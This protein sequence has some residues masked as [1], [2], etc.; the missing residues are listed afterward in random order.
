MGKTIIFV[1]GRSFKPQKAALQS[2]WFGAVEHGIGRDR[3]GKLA[4]FKKA[5]KELVYYGDLS[6]AFLRSKGSKYNEKKDVESRKQTLAALQGYNARQFTK[7]TYK[8]LPGKASY[9]EFLADV[10][11]MTLGPLRLTEGL[12]SVVAADMRHYWNFDSEF[13][14]NVRA[15]MI[16]P[17]K[18]AMNRGDKI[19]VI[20]HSLGTMVAYDTFWKFS[21]TSEYRP[22]YSNRKIDT[23]ITLGSP[24]GDETVKRNLKGAR[25]SGPRRYPGNIRRWEN[26][27]AEDDFISHD[28]KIANDYK[29]MYK[30]RLIVEINDHKI[31]NLAVRG[32]ASN[33]HHG[34]G[35][36]I[37][38]KVIQLITD[39]L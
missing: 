12:V 2:N 21:R 23:W 7:A 11:A 27:S 20:S 36:L 10:G 34:A 38:P 1:H 8:K 17:L 16:G 5:N 30:E 33:P 35:Y 29:R 3:Q 18:R 26:V 13:G 6:N 28:S 24:L 32:G 37:H 9:K 22:K 19:M 25:A 15:T 14:S 4:A 31:Y 39:W